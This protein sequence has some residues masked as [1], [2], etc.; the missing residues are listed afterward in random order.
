[1]GSVISK[2]FI[3]TVNPLSPG[4]FLREA[5]PCGVEVGERVGLRRYLYIPLS[6][7]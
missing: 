5:P 1:M 2:P 3:A 4:A 7:E 6:K